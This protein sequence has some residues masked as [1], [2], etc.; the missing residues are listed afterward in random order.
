MALPGANCIDT[1]AGH[2]RYLSDPW[3]RPYHYATTAT[4]YLLSAVDD[5]GK[6][7]G[8]AIERAVPLKQP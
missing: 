8:S 5:A 2:R 6:R 1:H 3:D 7:V 4:S